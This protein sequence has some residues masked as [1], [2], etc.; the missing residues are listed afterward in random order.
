[1]DWTGLD[2]KWCSPSRG[3]RTLTSEVS[4]YFQNFIRF[5]CTRVNIIA[6]TSI[7]KVRRFLRRFS[8]NSYSQRH[9][10][11]SCTKF[12]RNS[13]NNYGQNGHILTP[14][15]TFVAPIVT[16]LAGSDKFFFGYLFY[17]NLSKLDEKCRKCARIA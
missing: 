9:V 7:R 1:M 17:R 10:Q 6:F 13:G 11:V 14:S 15:M 12:R 4:F 16:T 3:A 2:C 8:R 5:H